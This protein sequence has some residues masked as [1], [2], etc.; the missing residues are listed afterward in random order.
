[1]THPPQPPNDPNQSYGQQPQQP[2]GQQSQ[3][4]QFPPFQPPVTP[5]PKAKKKWPW[6]VGGVVA[7]LVVV[8]AVGGG[9]DTDAEKTSTPATTSAAVAPL[10][11]QATSEPAKVT[12]TTPEPTAAPQVTLPEV[13]GQNGAIVQD[14]LKKLGLTNISLG[15]ADDKDKLV[16]MPNNWTAVS[17]EP[18]PGTVVAGD[19]LVVVT[20]TKK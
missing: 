15:S 8:A 2:F 19:D 16:I 18:A 13:A 7:L 6:I 17:I 4:G 9:E 12:T 1:M 14:K 3:Q 5:Q 11:P 20:L 10:V